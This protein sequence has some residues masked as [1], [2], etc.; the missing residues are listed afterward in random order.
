MDPSPLGPFFR[1][2]AFASTLVLGV[3]MFLGYL[4]FVIAPFGALAALISLLAGMRWFDRQLRRGARPFAIGPSR[5]VNAQRAALFRAGPRSQ[6]SR[7][8]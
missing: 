6:A 8:R 1:W 4:G 2:L 5:R 7:A 3:S